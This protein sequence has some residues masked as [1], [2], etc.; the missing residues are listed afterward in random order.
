M[1]HT[2]ASPGDRLLVPVDPFDLLAKALIP[3]WTEP[4]ASS[5]PVISSTTI[6]FE[7]ERASTLASTSN[8]AS[9]SASASHHVYRCL[10]PTPTLELDAN[11]TASTASTAAAANI[12]QPPCMV[13]IHRF[14]LF[15]AS[16]LKRAALANAIT[17]LALSRE[18]RDRAHQPEDASSNVGGYHSDRDLWSWPGVAALG[19]HDVLAAAVNRCAA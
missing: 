7:R 19:L 16:P 6:P 17:D 5:C 1:H 18:A 12:P 10:R 14:T 11:T 13:H 15:P 4:V 9:T 3:P 2:L 8:S